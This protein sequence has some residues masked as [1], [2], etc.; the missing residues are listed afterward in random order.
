MHSLTGGTLLSLIRSPTETDPVLTQSQR[1]DFPAEL[2]R[3]VIDGG[4]REGRP[5]TGDP[6]G[7]LWLLAIVI[8]FL[9]IV[10]L[11]V[12]WSRFFP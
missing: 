11:A 10:G 3:Q 8:A 6:T 9:V 5:E 12:N 7:L 4:V 2:E 1:T